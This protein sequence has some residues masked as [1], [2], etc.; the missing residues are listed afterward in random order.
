MH[1]IKEKESSMSKADSK[2]IGGT[3]YKAVNPA[4]EHWNLVAVY[5]WDYMQAQT[6]KYLMR[7]KLKN[8]VQDLYKAKHFLDKYIELVEEENAINEEITSRKLS[9]EAEVY[10]EASGSYV[11]QD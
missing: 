9:Q 5:N 7:W 11:A 2:Q 10:A 3:H 8:G 6:I 1:T 4:Q